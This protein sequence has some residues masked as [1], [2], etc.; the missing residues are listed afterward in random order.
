MPPSLSLS[1]HTFPAFQCCLLKS[2][3][4]EASAACNVPFMSLWCTISL[5]LLYSQKFCLSCTCICTVCDIYIVCSVFIGVTDREE[6]HGNIRKLK[7]KKRIDDDIK[8][9]KEWLKRASTVC[10]MYTLPIVDSYSCLCS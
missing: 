4:D 7:E 5:L 10:H 9:Y 3:G 6:S 2:L 1:L 8:N